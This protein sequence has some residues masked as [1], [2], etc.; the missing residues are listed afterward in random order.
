MVT[1]VAEPKARLKTAGQSAT[2]GPFK[3]TKPY[4]KDSGLRYSVSTNRAKT[5]KESF[6]QVSARPGVQSTLKAQSWTK[7]GD[8]KLFMMAMMNHRIPRKNSK[9]VLN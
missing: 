6:K 8:A 4:G 3:G 9:K 5:P 1:S 2:F 7:D